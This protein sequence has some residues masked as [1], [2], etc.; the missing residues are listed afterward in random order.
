MAGAATVGTSLFVVVLAIV[1]LV[2]LVRQRHTMA[3]WQLVLWALLIVLVPI[4]GLIAYLFWRISRSEAMRD[5][6]SVPRDQ[7]PPD[8]RPPVDPGRR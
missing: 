6:M 1:G 3:G 4:V 8:Q 7:T 2:D 5:A